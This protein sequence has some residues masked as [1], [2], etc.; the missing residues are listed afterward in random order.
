[1]AA[2]V[3]MVLKIPAPITAAIPSPVRSMTLRFLFRDAW[4]FRGYQHPG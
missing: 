3:P 4:F 2:A 1:M